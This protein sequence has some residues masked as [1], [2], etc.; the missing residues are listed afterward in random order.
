MGSVHGRF[1]EVSGVGVTITR[2]AV[3]FISML[4]SNIL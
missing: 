3:T 2:P 1:E 4:Q